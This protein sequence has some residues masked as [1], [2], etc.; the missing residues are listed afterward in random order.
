MQPVGSPLP[1]ADAS[2]TAPNMS[3]TSG[4]IILTLPG[5][6]PGAVACPTSGVIDKVG[7]GPSTN[8]S[9]AWTGAT[10]VLSPTQAA[11]RKNDGCIKTGSIT[12]DFIVLP[13]NPHN[14]SS[15]AKSCAPGAPRPQSTATI[16]I[17]ELMA[18]PANAATPSFGEWFEVK[19]YGGAPVNLKGWTIITGG[20]SQPDHTIAS[21]VIVPAGGYAV[22]GRSTDDSQN[23]GLQV[24]LQL[25]HWN[26]HDN[27]ARRSG[28]PR[29]RRHAGRTR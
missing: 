8:C 14:S 2:A 29:A 9:D 27:L 25:L 5:I 19:N 28:F 15:P 24:G 6:V 22:L 17:N 16:V 20:T 18:D 21:D 10:A 7:Y 1:T 12:N 4:K 3:A 13:P 11:F 26:C 23:G